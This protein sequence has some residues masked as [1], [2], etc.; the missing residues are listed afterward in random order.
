MLH[1]A[2]A[3]LIAT[4]SITASGGDLKS[5]SPAPYKDPQVNEFVLVPYS[6][7]LSE[8][9]AR[10]G[11]RFVQNTTCAQRCE[12]AFRLCQRGITFD[13]QGS[14][15]TPAMQTRYDTCV[16]RYGNCDAQCK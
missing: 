16:V 2:T 4:L 1:T 9:S 13:K 15:A 5:M 12:A 3:A 7:H 6:T 8:K 11:L 10:A 14:P